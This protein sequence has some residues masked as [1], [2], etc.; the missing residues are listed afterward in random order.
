[1][2][3]KNTSSKPIPLAIVGIGCLFPKANNPQQYWTNIR[4]G[5]DAIGDIPETHWNTADYFDEDKSAP[6]MTYAKRGGFIELQDFNPL[7]YGMSPNNIEATDTTQLLG[8]LVAKQALLDAG[9]STGKD[10]GDGREFDRDRTSV[11]L[12]VTGT[13]ELVIP[14]GARLGHP[15]WRKALKDAGVDPETTEDVVQRIADG[16]VPWQ[17]NSFPGLLGNVAAG[18]IANRFDL[19][20]TN[21]VV[22][23]ACASSLSA[24]HLAAMEL[25]AGR[26]DMA[27]T[28]GMDTFNDIFMYMCFSKTP[29]LSPTGN[30]RPFAKDGDG[31]ILGEGLGAV[32]LKRLDD[33]QRDGDKIYAVLKG[34]GSSSDGRGNAIYAPSSDGQTKALWNAYHAADVTPRSIQLVEAHGTGTSVGDAVEATALSGV[35][36]QDNEDE[37]W[38]AIGSVKSMIGHTKAAAGIA[39]LIKTSMALKHKV[40]PPSIKV[41]EPLEIIEPGTAPIYLNTSKRP[42]FN[43]LDTPRRAGLSS[44]GFGGSNFHCVLEEAEQEKDTIDWDGEVLIVALSA[45]EPEQLLTK[46]PDTKTLQDWELLRFYAYDSCQSFDTKQTHRLVA[47]IDKQA[48]DRAKLIDTINQRLKTEADCWSLPN[49]FYSNQIEHKKTAFVFPGQGSQYVGM[50]KDLACQFPQ[51]FSALENA[52]QTFL[53]ATDTSLTDIIY[54][55]PVFNKS[56]KKQQEEQLRQTENAQPA[57]GAVSMASLALLKYFGLSTDAAIGHS[58]GEL[59]ALC[60]ADS[61]SEDDLHYL[62][63]RRGELMNEGEG[64]RGGMLAVVAPVDQL[65][66]L[67]KQHAIDLVL[68][69]H[70]SPSQIVLSGATEE[71]DKFAKLAKAEK[72]RAIKLPVAAAFHSKYV[73]DAAKPFAKVLSDIQFSKTQMPVLSNTQ[74]EPY[75]DGIDSAKKLL[76]EQ[77]ANPVRFVEQVE[78]LY[79]E[80][81]RNFVEVGPGKTL[82]GLIDASLKDKT[83]TNVSIDASVGKQSGQYDLAL[84]LGKL[85][86]SG[87][88]LEINKWDSACGELTRPEVNAKPALTVPVGGANVMQSRPVRPPRKITASTNAINMTTKQAEPRITNTQKTSAQTQIASSSMLQATQESILALQKMQ[89]QTAKL[90]QQYLEGQETAQQTIQT[91]LQQQQAL[92]SGQQISMPVQPVIKQESARAISEEDTVSIQTNHADVS[93]LDPSASAEANATKEIFET[94]R[95]YDSFDIDNLLLKV[96]S[97]KT[98]YPLEML[99]LDMSL[100]TDLGIDSIKRVEILSAIQEQLPWS[101]VI[102]PEELGTFQFLQHIVEFL[103]E[104]K[105]DGAL[106]E[107]VATESDVTS[108][109]ETSQFEKSL[110]AIVAEKT[111]YPIDMLELDMNLD[112]DLGIDSIKRVEILSALQ[113]AMPELPTVGADE[114]NQLQTLRSIMTL[115]AAET[116]V[117]AAAK[118]VTKPSSSFSNDLLEIVA[119]KTGYPVDMLSLDMSLDGDLGID[120][121][122]R[123]EILSAMQERMPELPTVGAEQLSNL[124]TLQSIIE[125]FVSSDNETETSVDDADLAS[126]LLKVV[127]E[128]TGYPD[129]MLTLDMHLDSDLGID[130]IKRVEILSALQ[131]SLPDLPPVSADDLAVL[132][133]LQQI[134]DYMNQQNAS[135]S[136]QIEDAKAQQE[137]EDDVEAILER[138]VLSHIA[139]NESERD[140]ITIDKDKTLCITNGNSELATALSREL[141]NQGYKTKIIANGENVEQDI[142]GLIIC[143]DQ[144]LS[145]DKAYDSFALIQQAGESLKKNHGL[146]V[147]LTTLGGSFGIEQPMPA[148]VT[149]VAQVAINGMVKTAD[150]EW[151]EVYCKCI[152]TDAENLSQIINELFLDGPLEVAV[153]EGSKSQLSMSKTELTVPSNYSQLSN[154]DVIVISGGARGVTAEVAL[155]LAEM[156]QCSLLLLGR[157]PEPEQEPGWL[158]NAK[159]EAEIKR[160]ILEHSDKKM[161]PAE[162]TYA[163]RATLANREINNTLSRIEQTGANAIYR[164]VDITDESAVALTLDLARTELGNITGVIHAAGVL[165]DKLIEDKTR[166]QFV[167]VYS[168][169]VDGLQNLLSACVNDELKLIINFSSTTA[170]LGRKGQIDYAAANEVLNKMAQQEMQSRSNCKVLSIN[171]GPWDGGMVTAGL[172]KLFAEEGVGVIGLASGA[173]YLMNEIESDGP[174]EVVILA[175]AENK[176]LIASPYKPVVKPEID[177]SDLKVAF[178]RD[179]SVG[180]YSFLTSHV[181]NGQAVL[182]VA[183]ILEW[184][185]HGALHLNPGMQFHGFDDFRVLKGVTLSATEIRHLRIM[186]GNMTFNDNMGYVP[187][188]L[189]SDDKLHA[190]AVMVLTDSLSTTSESDKRK[191]LPVAQGEYQFKQ[192]EFYENGQLFHGQHLH[193]I[194]EVLHCSDKGIVADVNAAPAPTAWMSQPIRS[195]WLTDPLIL[196][197]AFQMMILWSFEHQGIGSLPTAISRYRQFFRS[198]PKSGAR[199]IAEVTSHTNNRANAD[200]EFLDENNNRIALMEGYECVRDNLLKSAF[201]NN[202]IENVTI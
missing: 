179:L 63:R 138:Y 112:S 118:T 12:G 29:A 148:H 41:D 59:S 55:I 161:T 22:D 88:S 183:V 122:K 154:D 93:T 21:C 150:K 104:G 180:S 120:S 130:S 189:R 196:D 56:E 103:A 76:A 136:T 184:F 132:Q 92:L 46:L 170:R 139:I 185:A 115:F 70:N 143:S 159:Q 146:L 147:S 33:A 100:D 91:L 79:E 90:H 77:L 133:T 153:K 65:T 198:F 188:E 34:M 144:D 172:K 10:A 6:D 57:I 140:Q 32:I 52:N 169:K 72:I 83:I 44:F 62:S 17:E 201:E 87:V 45:D 74:A 49:A 167:N 8:M 124:D 30:S 117:S 163:Y 106:T 119:D 171:W 190:S 107:P 109:T 175:E 43:K 38:C 202:Q 54:P 13:L 134:V 199:I 157:S 24:L 96:V 176:Q 114:L 187:L 166:E 64:D 3:K 19:G 7:L 158:A 11:V 192:R 195:N 50:G 95:Q 111:G 5:V 81:V 123:V 137:V 66:D 193:G 14:L 126:T 142:A 149:Q 178:E 58:Y 37:T 98:G 151:P 75:P 69:N 28:G 116:S 105:P 121:I 200:I 48:T 173:E 191:A 97:E 186:A 25:Q 127:A 125:L 160:V 82:S 113:E 99:S 129:E 23:A 26:V 128:K 141:S 20:G 31:T 71:I 131:E 36:R 39:G 60:A 73:A 2:S 1:M 53:Q 67:L 182:P 86:V 135:T 80:G 35:Y 47:V 18:R 194:K 78:K 108:S 155:K 40:L 101:P 16:Y 51:F 164:S 61:F 94:R 181:M 15:I 68:A 42:W 89:E 85:L 4:E 152:D 9:Y 102:K 156:Y 162:L 145:T 177:S 84:L 174:V 168:T 110:L 165:A 197:S 27:I